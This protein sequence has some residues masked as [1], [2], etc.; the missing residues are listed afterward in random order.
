[1]TLRPLADGDLLV[2]AAGPLPRRASVRTGPCA[3][4][5]ARR[6]PTS[7]VRTSFLARLGRRPAGRLRLSSY[8]GEAPARFDLAQLTLRARPAGRRG[9]RA[10][11]GRP[12]CRSRT[13]RTAPRRPWP[14]RPWRSSRYETSRSLAIHPDGKRFVLGTDWSLR[15]FAADGK[16]LWQRAVPGRR[17]G[18]QHHRRRPAGG[19]GLWRRHDPLAPD[20]ATARSC[21]PSCRWP[22]G[23]TG[24]PGRPTASTP[25]PRAP[26]A[27]CAGTSTAAGTQPAETIPVADIAELRRPDVLPLVLQETGHRPGARAGRAATAP[28]GRSQ[29]RT[30]SAVKPGAQLHVLAVGVSDYNPEH[31]RHLR[32]ELCRR[33]R[34]RPRRG[35]AEHPGQPLRQG[36]PAGP[37]QPVRHQGRHPAGA[38]HRLRPDAAGAGRRRGVPLLRPR[39]AGRRRALPAA[40]RGRCRATRSGSRARALEIGDLRDE[41]APAGRRAAGCWCCWMP[42]ARVRRPWTAARH[43][44]GRDGCCGRPWPRPT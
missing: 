14:T 37:A 39:R 19:G 1:M 16:L 28:A 9:D 25:P 40:L 33:R 10:A 31:A 5:T 6:R 27:C 43:R 38:G 8:G 15:A 2:A 18:G 20:G 44:G 35:A 42:A 34:P 26:T 13:G 11:R 36:Q 12:A 30:N 32:L 4:S 23:P 24:W 17:L 41:L 22:T 29:L 3:G 7:A 21:W